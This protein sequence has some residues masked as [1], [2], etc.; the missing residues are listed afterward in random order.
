MFWLTILHRAEPGLPPAIALDTI[1]LRLLD[2]LV[3]TKSRH[4]SKKAT[5]SNYIIKSAAVGG[6]LSR[7]SDPPPCDTVM[8]RG[9]SQA[10]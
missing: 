3:K 4:Q 8:W 7:A 1:L 9:K 10:Q 6:Y 2:E 5:I